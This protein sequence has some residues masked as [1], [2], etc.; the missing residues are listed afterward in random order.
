MTYKPYSAITTTGI[1]DT[2]TNDSGITIPKGTPVKIKPN[3]DI[4]FVNVS[5]EAD[6]FAVAGIAE[7]NIA[8]L[9]TG[10][11]ITTGRVTNITTT[12][13]FGDM[14]YID[15]TGALTNIK[16]SIGVNSFVAGDFVVSVGVIAKN[17][18]NPLNKDLVV[19]IDIVGQL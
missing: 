9:S 6:V 13:S 16:P 5:I 14:M 8:Y 10:S 18:S 3:G 12:A 15:K 19:V 4:D 7:S 11:I 1:A 2:R 17:S